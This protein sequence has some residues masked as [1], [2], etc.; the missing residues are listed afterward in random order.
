[1]G[2]DGHCLET[3]LEGSSDADLISFPMNPVAK[4]ALDFGGSEALAFL[5]NVGSTALVS[6]FTSDPNA[7]SFVGPVVEKAGF[8]GWE[9]IKAFYERSRSK[10]DIRIWKQFLGG[11]RGGIKNLLT[12]I[13]V[14]DPMYILMM[15]YGLRNSEVPAAAI[16]AV[17][18]LA[19]LPVAAFAQHYSGEAAHQLFKQAS[20]LYGFKW[21]TYYE[22]RFFLGERSKP[23]EVFQDLSN[24][25]SLSN[26]IQNVYD[27]NYHSNKLPCFSDRKVV[28]RSREISEEGD[29]FKNLEVVYTLARKRTPSRN[30]PFNYFFVE[31]EKARRNLGTLRFPF[32]FNKLIDTKIEGNIKFKRSVRYGDELRIALDELDCKKPVHVM[33]LKVYK[34]LDVL[35]DAMGYLMREYDVRVTTQPK[36]E[37]IG[38]L[39]NI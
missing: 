32:P 29:S 17:S 27:D 2:Q 31:K 26:S 1:M 15:Q 36:K 18:F 34:D 14:H 24:K 3:L 12:D 37:I 30:S 7:L 39:I 23:H 22:S 11:V 9:G 38:N 16:S 19:A 13:A 21:E 35:C 33:E 8:F 10:E 25:F 6:G 4:S 5:F 20:R 28:T